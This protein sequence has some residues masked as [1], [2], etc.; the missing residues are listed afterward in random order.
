MDKLDQIL[1][2]L[3]EIKRNQHHTSARLQRVERKLIGDKEF[4]DKGMVDLVNEHQQHIQAAK[5][6]KAKLIGFGVG[7]GIAG[8]G[9]FAYLKSLFQ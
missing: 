4:G 7:S 6:D 2:E 5:M 1:S 3:S 8:S 9:L